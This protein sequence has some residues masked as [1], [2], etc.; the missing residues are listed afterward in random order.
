[1]SAGPTSD[2]EV[3]QSQRSDEEILKIN[4]KDADL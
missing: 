1:M 4:R 2:I 3:I